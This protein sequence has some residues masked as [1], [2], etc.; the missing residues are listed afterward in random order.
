MLITNQLLSTQLPLNLDAQH[1]RPNIHV[2][3]P[4][5]EIISPTADDAFFEKMA[6]IMSQYP[7]LSNYSIS[8]YPYIYPI[9]PISATTSVAIYEGD[10]LL[11]DGT[12][13]ATMTEIFS[14]IINYISSTWSGT[15][16]LNSSTE[17][18]HFTP[19]FKPTMTRLPQAQTNF[20]A[21]D[22]SPQM[23]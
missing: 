5:L 6:Y 1:P 19:T 9:Y 2:Q 21:Q 12:S 20:S 14:P 7:Y 11:H 13:G 10:F 23:S 16:L 15:Y 8:A 3:L 22:C 18:P 4:T 17:Y